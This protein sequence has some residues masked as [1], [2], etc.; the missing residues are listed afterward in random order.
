VPEASPR[1]THGPST[2]SGRSTATRSAGESLQVCRR[3]GIGLKKITGNPEK[4]QMGTPV[5]SSSMPR[6]APSSYPAD[7]AA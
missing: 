5:R 4:S 7:L 6:A 3:A 2:V 1:T